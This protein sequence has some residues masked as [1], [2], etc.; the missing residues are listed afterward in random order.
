MQTLLEERIESQKMTI[1]ETLRGNL[2]RLA[3]SSADI[4]H[5][6]NRL[7]Q[8]LV[9]SLSSIPNCR[10][11]YAVE[12]HGIQVSSNIIHNG[13]VNHA[14]R[15]QNLSDR[16][17][18]LN[19]QPGEVFT[20]SPVYISR[21]DRKPCITAMHKVYAPDGRKLGCIAADFVIDDLPDNDVDLMRSYSWRQIKGD[22][23]IRQNLFAQERVSSAMDEKIDQV[24]DIIENLI[25]KRGIFHA[26]VHY[27]GSRATLWTYAHPYEYQLHVLDEIIDPN[28]CLAYPIK[29]YP[30]HAKVDAA[31]IKNVLQKFKMLRNID[32]IIYLRSASI[33][34]MNGMVGLTFSCDGSHYMQVEEFFDKQDVF[35]FGQ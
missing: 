11:L 10:M 27:S 18:F 12:C 30:E 28:V 5:Q 13:L 15:G 34:I 6:V 17:Y 24:H 1:T 7:D 25:T 3:N 23:A 29:S 32:E 22:P 26:K 20:L 21:T 14:T 33:N 35:W 31:D 19:N 8:Q 9:S 16:P 2:E 4:W